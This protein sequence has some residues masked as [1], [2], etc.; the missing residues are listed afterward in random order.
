ML[1]LAGI[2]ALT[3]ALDGS[4]VVPNGSPAPPKEIH[5]ETS[6][7]FCSVF[8]ENV[9]R[10]VQGLMFDDGLLSDG[11]GELQAIAR[12]SVIDGGSSKHGVGP[13]P[14][15]QMDRYKLGQTVHQIAQNLTHIYDL[16]GDSTQFPK[17]PK[18]D[19]Q[20]DLGLMR[21]RLVAVADQQVRS[22]N[23]MSGYYATAEMGDLMSRA[24]AIDAAMGNLRDDGDRQHLGQPVQATPAP[25]EEV[26]MESKTGSLMTAT[27]A[28]KVETALS[29]SRALTGSLEDKVAPAVLPGVT[30]CKSS[31]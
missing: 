21:A 29:Q 16:L 28:G 12:D 10:S 18:S 27:D 2:A 3:L 19:E 25:A 30:R 13:G 22:L 1:S 14:S 4:T 9:F 7:A 6:T 15:A 31:G 26:S 24:N 23:A 17:T 8:R 11:D 5:R 20:R